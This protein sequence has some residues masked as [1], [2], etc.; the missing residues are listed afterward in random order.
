MWEIK[1]EALNYLFFNSMLII[2]ENWANFFELNETNKL[3]VH[4]FNALNLISIS[5]KY[6][7]FW[8]SERR[9]IMRYL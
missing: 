3:L 9:N 2:P 6:Q 8:V 7:D 1:G 4:I 5:L